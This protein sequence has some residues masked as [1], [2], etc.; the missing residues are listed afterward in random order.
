MWLDYKVKVLSVMNLTAFIM[1]LAMFIDAFLLQYSHARVPREYNFPASL[2]F[3]HPHFS[4][5]GA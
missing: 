2:A 4:L 1:L 3:D 5:G